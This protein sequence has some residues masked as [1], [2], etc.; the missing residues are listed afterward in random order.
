MG[1]CV[2]NKEE[3]RVSSQKKQSWERTYSGQ[4]NSKLSEQNLING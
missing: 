4:E 2:S 1:G 3:Y